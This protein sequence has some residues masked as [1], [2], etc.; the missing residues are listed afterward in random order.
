MKEIINGE[1]LHSDNQKFFGLPSRL[2][3]KIFIYRMIFAD[4][5]SDRGYSGPAYAYAKDPDFSSTSA[6]PKYWEQV[7]DRF[8]TKYPEVYQ[9]S[10]NLIRE[11]TTTGRIVNPS[12]RFYKYQPIQRRGELD[13]PRTDILNY[14]VQGLAADFMQLARILLRYRLES[15]PADKVLLINTVHDDVECD[16]D[17]DPELVYNI[18]IELENAFK[19][20]P[21]L[22]FKTYGV[23]VNVPMAGEVKMGWSLY[24]AQMV[25]FKQETFEK[26]WNKLYGSN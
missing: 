9:H 25:K 11:A 12:G 5:F 19:A 26:D 13:W 3:A 17:N 6:R 14:P 16:V 15:Y 10:I 22:F 2:I 1:D 8:F 21:E 24:E 7:I 4:A 20:I 18:S 23:R